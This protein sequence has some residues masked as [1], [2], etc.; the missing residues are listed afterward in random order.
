MKHLGDNE[1]TVLLKVARLGNVLEADEKA[2][3]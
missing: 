1:G 3:G 2:S